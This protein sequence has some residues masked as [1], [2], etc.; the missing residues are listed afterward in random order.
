MGRERS[1]LRTDP[2]PDRARASASNA[3]GAG[4]CLNLL[5]WEGAFFGR[6]CALRRFSP[7]SWIAFWESSV[8]IPSRLGIVPMNAALR[9]PLANAFWIVGERLVITEDWHAELWLDGSDTVA[10]YQR[11]WETLR[12]SA[13]VRCGGAARYRSGPAGDGR[14]GLW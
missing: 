13:G 7:T 4:R 9:L 6:R 2:A 3:Y 5:M 8:W 1:V 11:V 12:E 14:V 10:L